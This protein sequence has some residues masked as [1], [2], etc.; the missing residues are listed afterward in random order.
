MNEIM[1]IKVLNE[2]IFNHDAEQKNEVTLV[3]MDIQMSRKLQYIDYSFRVDFLRLEVDVWNEGRI[4]S[5]V[6]NRSCDS[7]YIIII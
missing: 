2:L 5:F 3:M 4:G 1:C 7:S 6:Q